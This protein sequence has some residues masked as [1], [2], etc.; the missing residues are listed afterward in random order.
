MGQLRSAARA[1]ALEG[2]SPAA[3]A[4]RMSVYQRALSPDELTTLIYAVI[5]PDRERLRFVNAGH[6]PPLLLPERGAPRILTGVTPPL[7]V[8]DLPSHPETVAQFPPG[9]ALVLYTDGLVERRGESIDA[10]PAA[11]ARRARRAAAAA[12]RRCA[13][14]CSTAAWVRPAATTT[15]PRCS[16]APSRSSGPSARFTLSPDPEALGALRR[17]LRRWL[18]EAGASDDDVAAVTMAANE[19][20]ENAIEH[21]HAFAPVPISVSFER[22]DDDVLVTVHDAGATPG[23]PDPDRGR[24]LALM[25]G[26]DGRGELQLR[27]ALRRLGR[28]APGDWARP[29]GPGAPAQARA[30]RRAEPRGAVGGDVSHQRGGLDQVYPIVGAEYQCVPGV[31]NHARSEPRHPPRLDRAGARPPCGRGAARRLEPALS[32]QAKLLVSELVTN[33]V[34]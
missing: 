12:S 7:G 22:R 18:A 6:P 3:F 29:R 1:Y 24:G 13:I 32:A 5:E 20:W 27:R 23:E 28:A 10:R 15:S 4:Q 2:H 21:A 16:C 19:A 9:A 8:S 17:T 14:A 34:K 33:A 31:L 11:P 25:Q 30:A 26:A